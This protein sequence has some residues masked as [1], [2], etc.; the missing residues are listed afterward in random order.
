MFGSW[1]KMSEHVDV[2]HEEVKC[3]TA[4]IPTDSGL[5]WFVSKK[6]YSTSIKGVFQY[7][8]FL[9]TKRYLCS[10][11]MELCLNWDCSAWRMLHFSERTLHMFKECCSFETEQA[12]AKKSCIYLN[13]VLPCHISSNAAFLKQNIFCNQT[14]FFVE[15]T[16]N[17]AF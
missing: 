17:Y 9:L 11:L 7:N 8:S 13:D 3:W 12:S 4:A 6:W 5:I 16:V 10:L 2:R 14:A 1:D 15:G